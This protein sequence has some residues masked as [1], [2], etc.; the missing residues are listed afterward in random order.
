MKRFSIDDDP[1]DER[2]VLRDGKT[3]RTPMYMMDSLQ[4]AIATSG[5]RIT[6]GAGKGGL[7]LNRPSFRVSDTSAGDARQRARDDYERDLTSAWRRCC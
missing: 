7:A 1:F 6:D 3:Y 2:G 4:R 5:A